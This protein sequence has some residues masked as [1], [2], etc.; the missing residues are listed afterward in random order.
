MNYDFNFCPCTKGLWNHYTG[1]Q[2]CT[3]DNK[4]ENAEK[5]PCFDSTISLVYSLLFSANCTKSNECI[6]IV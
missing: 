5:I 2:D 6:N 1:K 4:I 3:V